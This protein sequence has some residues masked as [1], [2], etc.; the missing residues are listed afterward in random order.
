MVQ[1]LSPWLKWGDKIRGKWPN[2]PCHITTPKKLGR[3]PK[4]LHNPYHLGAQIWA[5][6]V[7]SP[8][9]LGDPPKMG[10]GGVKVAT[11]LGSLKRGGIQIAAKRYEKREKFTPFIWFVLCSSCTPFAFS[12]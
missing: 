4:W 10:G 12:M 7:N 8:C 1:Q 9:R 2:S 3:K 6:W 11:I 5:K